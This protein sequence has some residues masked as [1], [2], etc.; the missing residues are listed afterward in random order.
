MAPAT[1]A[2]PTELL[3]EPTETTLIQAVAGEITLPEGFSLASADFARVGADLVLTAPGG[4]QIVIRDFFALGE[5]PELVSADGAHIPGDLA[6]KLAGPLAPGQ[7]AQVAQAGPAISP[8]PI[9]QVDNV[10]GE[11]V[12][13]RPDGTRVDLEVGDPVYQGDVLES[14]EDGAIGIVLADETSFSM[15]E[16][17]RMV[18]DEMVYGPGTQEGKIVLSV[19]QGVFTFISGE[20]SKADPDA[21]I[22]ETPVA[23]IGIRGT[24]VGIAYQEGEEMQLVLME[25][26]DGFIGEVVIHNAAGIQ[27]LNQANQGVTVAGL[28]TAPSRPETIS[29]EA[30][31]ETFGSALA[32]MPESSNVNTYGAE[33]AMAEDGTEEELAEAAALEEETETAAGGDEEGGV[34]MSSPVFGDI[35]PV[36]YSNVEFDFSI[37]MLPP[38]LLAARVT[39][40]AENLDDTLLP[41]NVFGRNYIYGTE[42]DDILIGAN[43]SDWIYGL[44][45]DDILIGLLNDDQLNGGEGNDILNG[46][47]GWDVASFIGDTAGVTVDLV[48]GSAVGS[49]SGNDTLINIEQVYGGSGNDTF[50]GTNGIDSFNG[51]DGDDTVYGTAGNDIYAGSSGTDTLNFASDTSGVTVDLTAETAFGTAIGNDV[52]Q[53]FENVIGGSGDDTIKG[54]SGV[55]I[56]TGGAGDDT[57]IGDSGGDVIDGG[58][59]TDILDFSAAATGTHVNLAAGTTNGAFG[60]DTLTGIE[61]A[62]GGAATDIFTGDGNDNSYAGGGGDDLVYGSAGDD[63]LRGGSGTGDRLDYSAETV[64]VTVSLAAGTATGS[65]IGTDTIGGFE[66]VDTGSGDDTL[67]GSAG[68]DNFVTGSGDDT[69]FGTA[70]NDAFTGGAGTD[71][72]SYANDS[73]GVMVNLFQQTATGAAIGS[74]IVSGFENVIGGSG[75]DTIK[76]SS[77]VNILTGGAGDDTFIGDSGGD[78]IDGGTGTDILDFSAAAAGTHVNLAAGTTNGAFGSDTLTGIEGAIGGAATDIFTGDGNDNSYAGGGGGDLVY[79]SAGDDTLDGGSGTGDRLDYFADTAGIIVNLTAG[80]ATGSAIGTD[81]ISNFER[82]DGGSGGDS[83][84]GSSGADILLGF[85]GDDIVFGTAGNDG[86]GGGAGIDTI[87]YVNDSTGVTVS[88]TSATATGSAIGSDAVSGFEN[89]I[90]G[91]GDDTITGSSGINILTGGGGGDILTG[92]GGSDIFRYTAASDS[93]S[94][95][96]D[97]ITDFSTADASEDIWLDGFTSNPGSFSFLGTGAFTDTG[98]VQARMASNGLLEIDADGDGTADMEITMTGVNVGALDAGDFTVT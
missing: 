13:I 45:G 40:R 41:F 95:L 14:G 16:N 58:T 28:T 34:A 7:V 32:N 89:V 77:G 4:A 74:D 38:H 48:V 84:T 67:T 10:D 55:N 90:G 79:G 43:N 68:D 37:F 61:G 64:S 3:P 71:T 2:K 33:E 26:G 88:L 56:L 44:G 49:S 76:G 73:A 98:N 82:I 21:M 12:A 8:E 70:G 9:G 29:P 18:L 35:P 31:S 36:N 39:G 97:I 11:V 93:T 80:T 20:V 78:V 22:V 65:T 87:S 46:G 47:N 63:T 52:V 19:V 30:I 59:G 57:F 23:T 17:G 81:T 50:T 86:L 69:V 24:Q 1:G 42:G 25:E 15:A 92:S 27:I 54:S 62:I 53:T 94:I 60:N 66:R 85:C 51:Y 72:V 96:K 83:L 91:T 6:A 75:D 5:F